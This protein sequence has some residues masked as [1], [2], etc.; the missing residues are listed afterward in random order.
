MPYHKF[1]EGLCDA[2]RRTEGEP[3]IEKP[4]HSKGPEAIDEGYREALAR[5]SSHVE[6]ILTHAL[7]AKVA[8]DLWRR[9]PC[10][11]LQVFTADVDDSGFDLVLGCKG[12]M[13]YIQIKQTHLL[14]TAVKYSLR[15][16]FARI[17]GACAVVL[18]YEGTTLEI[19]HCLFLGG[20]PA[21][22]IADIEGNRISQS[23]GRRTADG[24][25]KSRE[26]YRDVP[27]RDFHG[28]LSISELVDRLFP[29]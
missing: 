20:M 22:P 7:I 13:R 29:N 15:L 3:H 25:R 28:P 9:D 18:I 2:H 6:N 16:D 11:D 1:W 26:N 12:I 27:R 17:T 4:S 14:G 21:E 8:Q 10:L 5:R 23:P 19:D 24:A